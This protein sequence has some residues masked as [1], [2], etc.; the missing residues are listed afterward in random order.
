PGAL[1]AMGILDEITHVVLAL[2]RARRDPRAMIDAL[3]WFESRV[4][5][6]AL[7]AA[8]LAFAD[9]FPTVA[10]YRGLQS[11]AD[12][13]AGETGGVP[14]RAVALEELITV[15]LA[16]LNPAFRPFR[17]LFDD[18]ALAAHTVYRE[19]SGALRAYFDSRP[20]F[21]PSDQNLI[22]ML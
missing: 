18:D 21:G 19:V 4:T 11:A 8:L 2:Y 16:N 12:W 20:R 14:H 6:A 1:N 17:E 13:L 5:P 7:Q 15:W 9:R 3:G 22:D 10:V